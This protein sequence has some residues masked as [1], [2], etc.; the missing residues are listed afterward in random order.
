MCKIKTEN[1]LPFVRD[2]AKSL[3]YSLRPFCVLFEIVLLKALAVG[4]SLEEI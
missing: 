1:V 2:G 4:I 3:E